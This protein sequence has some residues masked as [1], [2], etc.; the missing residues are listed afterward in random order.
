MLSNIVRKGT[1]KMVVRSQR[2]EKLGYGG[3]TGCG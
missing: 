3:M 2:G 1:R